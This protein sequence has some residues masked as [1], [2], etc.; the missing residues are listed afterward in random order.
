MG[1]SHTALCAPILGI[2]T[3]LALLVLLLLPLSWKND[4][5]SHFTNGD[6]I[7]YVLFEVWL[8]TTHTHTHTLCM[9]THA[10]T[11][12][13]CVCVCKMDVIPGLTVYCYLYSYWGSVAVLFLHISQCIVDICQLPFSVLV[14]SRLDTYV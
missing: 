13:V 6:V 1:G 2:V 11:H 8:Q 3:S 7:T 10:L 9:H 4:P 12:S 5:T 14:T